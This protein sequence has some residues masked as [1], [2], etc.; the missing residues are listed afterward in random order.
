MGLGC[1]PPGPSVLRQKVRQQERRRA[2]YLDRKG[3]CAQK[4][5]GHCA[6][7]CEGHCAQKCEGHCAQKCEGHCAQKCEGHR[8]QSRGEVLHHEVVLQVQVPMHFLPGSEQQRRLPQA[9]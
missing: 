4:W 1:P 5:E 2:E 8:A 7:K 6:Q 9:A 3:H